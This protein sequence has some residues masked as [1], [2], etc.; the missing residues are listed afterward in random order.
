MKKLIIFLLFVLMINS[1]YAQAGLLSYDGEEIIEVVNLPNEE[2]LK[3]PEGEYVD[4]GYIYKSVEILFVPI[5]NYDGRLVGITGQEGTYLELTS[6]Q[7]TEIILKVGIELP[8]PPYLDLWHRIG[9][10]V[11]FLMAILF[12]AFNTRNKMKKKSSFLS[13][14]PT[15]RERLKDI[16]INSQE[17]IELESTILN[18]EGKAKVEG[19]DFIAVKLYLRTFISISVFDMN[20]ISVEQVQSNNDDFFERLLSLKKELSLKSSFTMHY[21]YFT[22]DKS[23]T[24]DEIAT[25]KS[26]KNRSFI[27]ATNALPVIIDFEKMEVNIAMGS[28]PPKNIL[29]NCFIQADIHL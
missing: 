26:L 2:W 21:I 6:D 25:L 11:V 7:I 15:G 20:K 1:N 12:F 8:E 29:E 5:W 22:F 18:V 10:K 28:T 17:F 19:L 23:P 13:S 16:L 9:G 14:L 24:N 3:T 4:I 27:K